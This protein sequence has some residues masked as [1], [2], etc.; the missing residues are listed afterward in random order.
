MSLNRWKVL[1]CTL[2]VGVGGLAVF[3][4][5]PATD[6]PADPPAEP[7]PLPNL[8][9]KPASHPDG[10]DTPAPVKPVKGGELDPDL[11]F[12]PPVAAKSE[13]PVKKPANE[14]VFEPITPA[15]VPAKAETDAPPQPVKSD[16]KK[17][18]DA[19]DPPL[20]IPA[21]PETKAP[22]KSE[23]DKPDVATGDM[24]PKAP[25]IDLG[26]IPPPPV[27]PDVPAPL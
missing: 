19:P 21:K 6:K 13:E 17:N 20:L 15:V 9:V 18:G 22:P 24:P 16:D 10:T 3:A 1:A 4:R 11:P 27:K 2:T 25:V 23:N 5:P 8:T 12:V 7:A 26:P 14:P